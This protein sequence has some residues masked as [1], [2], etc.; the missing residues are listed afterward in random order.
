VRDFGVDRFRE[1]LRQVT[2]DV[3]FATED[4][5]EILGGELPAETWVLKRGA[6]GCLFARDGVYVELPAVAG[7]V[8]DSTGAGDA[9][10]AAF[11]LGG[12]LDEAARRAMD[13][14]ARCV[15]KL[16]SMP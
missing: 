15:S 9:L 14:A 5:R 16:G 8:V 11:L 10:A 7:E 2:P 13:A 4:E 12:P 3:L 1:R 6:A